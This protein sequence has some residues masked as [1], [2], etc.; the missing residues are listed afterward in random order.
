MFQI[1]GKTIYSKCKALQIQEHIKPQEIDK[2]Q[3]SSTLSHFLSLYKAA[4]NRLFKTTITENQYLS[5]GYCTAN[6]LDMHL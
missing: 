5:V 3:Y 2:R 6:L 4:S 1:I